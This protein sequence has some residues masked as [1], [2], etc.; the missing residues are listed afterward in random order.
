MEKHVQACYFMGTVIGQSANILINK[1]KTESLFAHGFGNFRMNLSIVFTLGLAA[2]LVNCP[3]LN[4]A[5]NMYPLK[6][7]W[8]APALP[9]ALF[10]FIYGELRKLICRRFPKSWFDHEFTW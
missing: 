7:A 5:F 8:Y 4:V 3:G 9:F 1:T 2:F 10:I 6:G